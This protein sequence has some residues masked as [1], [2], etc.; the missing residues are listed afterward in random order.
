MPKDKWGGKKGGEEE[1]EEEE[2]E[3]EQEDGD[4]GYEFVKDYKFNIVHYVSFFPRF[5]SWSGGHRGHLLNPEFEDC[6]CLQAYAT[7]A[8]EGRRRTVGEL[9]L[10]YERSTRQL[11]WVSVVSPCLPCC[12]RSFAS[13]AKCRRCTY[14]SP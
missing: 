13:L 1:G 11:A 6:F 12:R 5:L 3:E 9:P 2:E 7:P 8:H 14:A 4:V 10:N